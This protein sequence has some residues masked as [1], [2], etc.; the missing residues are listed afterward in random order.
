MS[1][2]S[3]PFSL[4]EEAFILNSL[5]EV[6]KVWARATGKATFNFSVQDGQAHL[7]LGFQLGMPGDPHL[8]PHPPSLPK[9]KT[10]F[11]RE[12]DRL[13]AAEH[14]ERLNSTKIPNVVVSTTIPSSSISPEAISTTTVSVAPSKTVTH[15][16]VAVPATPEVKVSPSSPEETIA[17]STPL[18]VSTAAVS[19]A[20]L[21][22]HP[23]CPTRPIRPFCTPEEDD[24]LKELNYFID[25]LHMKVRFS[26]EKPLKKKHRAIMI[27]FDKKIKEEPH[28]LFRSKNYEET[29]LNLCPDEERNLYSNILGKLV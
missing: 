4:S 8:P 3:I 17:I 13:R 19:A 9:A 14:Q 23:V 27:A 20:P 2:N 12:R 15:S 1:F 28:I 26:D 10:S 25:D 24:P 21:T 7:Q 29:F 5:S 6:T 22:Y 16:K 18:S 11:R